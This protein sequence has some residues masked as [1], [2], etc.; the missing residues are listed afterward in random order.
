MPWFAF[1]LKLLSFL[2]CAVT[3]VTLQADEPPETYI[4]S[5][6]YDLWKNSP[7]TDPPPVEEKEEYV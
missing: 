3:A 2:L 1:T 7:F 5:R 6:Y 4:P